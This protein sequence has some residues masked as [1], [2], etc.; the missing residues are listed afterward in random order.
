M[1]CEYPG[2]VQYP[3]RIGGRLARLCLRGPYGVQNPERDIAG[4]PR[5]IQMLHSR[6]RLQLGHKPVPRRTLSIGTPLGD[7][8]DNKVY[9]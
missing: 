5:N 7:S 9:L 6:E 3:W 8:S 4:A 2:L 1:C